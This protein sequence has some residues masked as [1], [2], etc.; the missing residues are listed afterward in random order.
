MKKEHHSKIYKSASKDFKKK[1]D[2]I[3]KDSKKIMITS[4]MGPDDD[5]ISSVLSTY[6]YLQKYL[7]VPSRNIKM[8][9]SGKKLDRWSYFFNFE[10]IK[11]V[12][13]IEKYSKEFDLIICLDGGG[14][15]RFSKSEKMKSYEGNTVCI[16]HHPTVEGEF[17]LHLVDG[18]SPACAV[19]LYELFFEKE[20]NLSKE[21]CEILMLGIIGDTGSFTYIRPEDSKTLNIAAR[22]V[23]EG[24]IKIEA[25]KSKY[26][27]I[28]SNSFKVLAHA[29]S[30]SEIISTK[31]WPDF[32]CS[33]IRRSFVKNNNLTYDEVDEGAHLLRGILEVLMEEHGVL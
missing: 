3:V 25:L 12:G 29:M 30:N 7:K 13:D 31:N 6:I 26:D 24:E 32:M 2:S 11:F 28:N 14:W 5:S 16:D 33:Y 15:K 17:S 9:Y 23:K 18:A 4:H 1:F 21:L 10:K 22:L 19:L 20:K 8:M 27:T